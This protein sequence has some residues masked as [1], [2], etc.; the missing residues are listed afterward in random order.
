MVLDR[1]DDA[2]PQIY[3]GECVEVDVRHAFNGPGFALDLV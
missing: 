1:F 3:G 2:Y